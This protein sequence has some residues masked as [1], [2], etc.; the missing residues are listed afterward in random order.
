MATIARFFT[1]SSHTAQEGTRTPTALRPL[2]PE[3]SASTNSATW[4]WSRPRFGAARGA[5][6]HE[7]R[8]GSRR[9]GGTDMALPLFIAESPPALD[10]YS[11]AVTAAAERVS[12]AVV[13]I[14]VRNG[15]GGGNGSG[16][17]FT[18]DGFVLT[19]SHVVHGAQSISV[20]LLDGRE[21]P[22]RLDRRRSAYRSRG[23][24][25]RRAGSAARYARRFQRTSARTTRRCGRQSV[26]LG[27]HGHGRRGERARTNVALAVRAPDG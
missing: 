6:F 2:V 14:E 10:P 20:A 3:T 13:C 4:A 7:T 5:P 21:L 18:P 23:S 15:R 26:R 9:F 16:F 24:A 1:Y 11:Q 19:N 12:P 22:A 17:I 25:A 27:L 8:A